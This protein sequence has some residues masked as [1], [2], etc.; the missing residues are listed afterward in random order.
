M[1]AL[2]ALRELLSISGLALRILRL[3]NCQLCTADAL[4]KLSP[5][6]GNRVDVRSIEAVASALRE[7]KCPLT[8]VRLGA[9]R[10]RDVESATLLSAVGENSCLSRVQL[11]LECNALTAEGLAGAPCPCSWVCQID[12]VDVTT[13]RSITPPVGA[14]TPLT[15]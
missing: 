3:S 15:V 12:A 5:H 9:N 6:N 11:G 8:E 1:E 14:S 2:E 10:I 4:E 13:N 7:C